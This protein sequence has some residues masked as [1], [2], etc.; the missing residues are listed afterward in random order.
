MILGSSFDFKVDIY[1]LGIIFFE[2]LN[3]FTTEMERCKTLKILREGT[4]PSQFLKMYKDTTEVSEN[5][6][7]IK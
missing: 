4:M 1:S 7:K 2:L 6:F 5:M 3:S